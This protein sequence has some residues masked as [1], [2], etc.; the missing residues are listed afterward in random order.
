MSART[1]RE[2]VCSPFDDVPSSVSGSGIWGVE[3]LT[4]VLDS[5]EPNILV[6]DVLHVLEPLPGLKV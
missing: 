2:K 4:V 1:Y 3:V 5:A 6:R